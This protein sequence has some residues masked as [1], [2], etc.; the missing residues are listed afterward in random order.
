MGTAALSGVSL[1]NSQAGTSRL[2]GNLVILFPV[3]HTPGDS[4]LGQ[5]SRRDEVSSLP[6]IGREKRGGVL[7]G[8]VHLFHRNNSWT[9]SASLWALARSLSLPDSLGLEN[10]DDVLVIFQHSF[11][12]SS[13]RRNHCLL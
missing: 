5:K 6:T 9:R 8:R 2:T 4:W 7:E 1:D 12:V 10:A 13:Y 3:P 11:M